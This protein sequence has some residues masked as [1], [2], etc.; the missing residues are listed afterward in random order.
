MPLPRIAR[1]RK[2][3]AI[4]AI[5]ILA[6]LLVALAPTTTQAAAPAAAACSLT[7]T[8]GLKTIWVGFELR[9]YNLRVPK[10]LTGN[11]PLLIDMHGL[12]SNAVFQEVTSGWTPYAASKKFIV[13][14]PAGSSWGQSWDLN[15]NSGDSKFVRKL[16]ETLKSTYCIDSK[17]VY[18]N[19]GSLGGY[20]A[21]RMACDHE[22]VFASVAMTISGRLDAFPCGLSRPVSIGIFNVEGDPLFGTANSIVTRDL[23]RERNGCSDTAVADPNPYGANG[24]VYNDCDGDAS[25]LWRTYTGDSHAYPTGDALTDLHDKTWNFLLAHPKP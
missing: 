20:M 8:S 13:A 6:P 11:V 18:A 12:G 9:S 10:G 25:V 4:A 5:G 3:A 7:P 16:A 15:Q 14:Y 24:A 1:L 2:L 19:G 17:R 21:Q 23:W 22:D